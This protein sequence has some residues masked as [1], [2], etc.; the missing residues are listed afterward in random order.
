[1]VEAK[2]TR[3]TKVL[4]RDAFFRG[5]DSNKTTYNS[6]EVRDIS[7]SLQHCGV[8]IVPSSWARL[9]VNLVEAVQ[10]I[11]SENPVCNEQMLRCLSRFC[12]GQ[13]RVSSTADLNR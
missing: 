8:G 4:G 12:G 1:M 7:T 11:Y 6:E 2:R 9:T 5:T 3:L 10:F 13:L